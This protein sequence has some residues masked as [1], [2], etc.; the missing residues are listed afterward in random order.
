MTKIDILL[1]EQFSPKFLQFKY[2]NS[3]RNRGFYK[4]G[5]YKESF[6]RKS[7]REPGLHTG[8]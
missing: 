8:R 2:L 7:R 4:G 3:T 5:F 1:I 6:P